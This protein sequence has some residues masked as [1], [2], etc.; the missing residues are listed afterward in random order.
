MSN[1]ESKTARSYRGTVVDDNAIV[2]INLKWLGQLL[3]LTG[4]LVYGYWRIESRLGQLEEAM[5]TADIKIG[6]L[7]GKH[8]VEETI[9]REQL[10]EKVA[11]YEKSVGGL[12]PLSW[13]KK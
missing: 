10:E 1:G 3:V 4:M 6:D 7:L 12:N 11:W 5:V 13:K 2:S 9:Q 8:I